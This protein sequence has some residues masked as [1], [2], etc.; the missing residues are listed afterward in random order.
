MAR[1]EQRPLETVITLVLED[2]DP[3]LAE[4]HRELYPERI[5][6]HIP[7]SLTLLYPWMPAA[8]VSETDLEELRTFFGERSPFEFELTRVDEFPG[9]VAY[10]VPEP[11]DELR[12]L[13][14]ALWAKYP[15]YPR[16]GIPDH[17]PPPHATL[18]RYKGDSPITLE[19]ARERVEP[20]LP[21]RCT[22]TEATL[23]EEYELDRMRIRETFPLRG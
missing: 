5:A 6:E 11:D 20:L 17:E 1:T 4:A 9:L 18:G 7:F 19:R 2:A 3:A 13:M 12:A 10:A 21:V 14:R 22:V 23:I 16:Y 8:E 15:Q